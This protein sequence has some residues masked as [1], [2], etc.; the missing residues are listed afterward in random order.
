MKHPLLGCCTQ[1]GA[2]FK[3]ETHPKRV[4]DSYKSKATGTSPENFQ[5]TAFSITTLSI[6]LFSL[7]SPVYTGVRCRRKH[8]VLTPV[9][10]CQST[11][12]GAKKA[13]YNREEALTLLQ[14]LRKPSGTDAKWL[15]NCVPSMR[16]NA[17]VREERRHR[18]DEPKPD[19]TAGRACFLCAPGTYRPRWARRC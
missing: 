19:E 7:D 4:L 9:T 14:R 6:L 2:P 15:Q 18:E 12:I 11:R 1:P 10:A 17:R 16:R 3:T 5:V 8:Y 13:R